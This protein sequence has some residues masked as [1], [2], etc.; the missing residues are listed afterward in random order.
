MGE[1]YFDNS[2][3]Y[4]EAELD[5]TL[6]RLGVDIIDVYYVHRRDA[7]IPIEEVSETLA[8]FIKAGKI[9]SFGFPKSPQHRLQGPM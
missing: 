5:K 9:K 1:R 3:A 7:A 4:L 2:L 6:A 8:G